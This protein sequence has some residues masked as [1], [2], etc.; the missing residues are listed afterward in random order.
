MS[1][2]SDSHNFAVILAAGM[3]ARMGACKAG[4]PW[5]D[6]PSLLAYQATQFLQAKILPIVVLGPHN[7]HQQV[8]CPAECQ[9]VVNP[10]PQR[11]KTSSILTG[12]KCLPDSFATV[13]ISAVDQ[14]RPTQI[15]QTLLQTHTQTQALITAPTYHGK[16]GHPLLFDGQM[17]SPL[18][19]IREETYGLRQIMH[20]FA[21]QINR[22][23][24]A[25][26]TVLSDL[27]TPEL[28]EAH[29]QIS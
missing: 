3:S 2:L 28:Y 17:R 26:S 10:A 29:H 15:Y 6:A 14:P 22:I 11:G 27:N 23:E 16:L 9:V 13:T 21:D 8:H 19:T 7:L 20:T 25:S 24:F 12:L 5:L 18:F 4:L 1:S